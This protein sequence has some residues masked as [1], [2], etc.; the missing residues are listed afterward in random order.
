MNDKEEVIQNLWENIFVEFFG[1]SRFGGE[2]ERHRNIRIGSTERVIT[3]IIIKEGSTDLFIVELKQHNLA[4]SK[5]IELQ[6]I[7]YLKQLRLDTGVLVC[8]KIYIY[9]YDYSKADDEQDR[10]EIEFTSN[11]P[12][13]VRFVEMFGKS[14]FEK[15]AV[16]EFIRLQSESIKKIDRIKAE[17]TA[18]LATQLLKNYFSDKYGEAEFAKAI[19]VF[20]VAIVP[21]SIAPAS[22]TPSSIRVSAAVTSERIIGVD[23]QKLNRPKQKFVISGVPCDKNDFE[24]YLRGQLSANVKI[25]LLYHDGQTENKIWRVNNFGAHSNL[26]GNL[27]SG[28]LRDWR[29][30]GIVGIELEV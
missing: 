28:Y 11:N 5:A 18:E 21:K 29:A 1:Y 7:S 14:G 2:I 30:K 6:L 24:D 15:S 22:S 20:S 16:R 23:I 10:A 12:D 8:D 3:D 19:E 25:T 9:D 26:S 4:R 27:A 13:G 17:L